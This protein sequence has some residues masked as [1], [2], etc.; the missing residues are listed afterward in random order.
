[1]LASELQ[2]MPDSADKGRPSSAPLSV[3]D[4]DR[5]ADSFHAFWDDEPAPAAAA[6]VIATTPAAATAIA[7]PAARPGAVTAPMPVADPT[8]G[9]VTA[10][11][12]AVAPVHQEKPVGKQTLIGIAPINIE[13]PP[14]EPP[15]SSSPVSS[16]PSA[17]VPGYAV[18]YTPKDPPSTPAMVIA[19]EAQSS[20]DNDPP[21]A[22]R[23][24]FSQTMP[25]QRVRS[26]P[27]ASVAPPAV[28]APIAIADDF[29]PYAPKKGK[30]KVI[31]LVTGGTLLLLVSVVAIRGLDG[32]AHHSPAQ[33]SPAAAVPAADVVRAATVGAA[34]PTP[35]P[36]EPAPTTAPESPTPTR[37][38][39]REP[40]SSVARPTSER[41]PAKAKTKVKSEAIAPAPRPTTRAASPEA[42]PPAPKPASK[43]V[44]VR[45]APF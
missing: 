39:A 37:S 41:V 5:L 18:A 34:I 30:G 3:E 15:P 6:P 42:S 44:I 38:V 2:L 29:N 7:E 17:D 35:E 28:A 1:M 13:R 36:A 32:A 20:P 24:Q 31:A 26:S 23:R 40:E 33:A 45:D 43:G 9:A 4:A 19:P 27:H 14:S 12:P 21:P 22:K 16:S 8:P 10:P 25:A 11:M